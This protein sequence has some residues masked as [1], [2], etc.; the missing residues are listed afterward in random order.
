MSGSIAS[1]I[2]PEAEKVVGSSYRIVRPKREASSSPGEHLG[3]YEGAEHGLTSRGGCSCCLAWSSC[4]GQPHFSGAAFLNPMSFYLCRGCLVR[5]NSDP[6]ASSRRFLLFTLAVSMRW[7]PLFLPGQVQLWAGALPW[8]GLHSARPPSR[9]RAAALHSSATQR[10][11]ERAPALCRRQQK[12]GL[13]FISTISQ[14]DWSMS[15]CAPW[16]G[17]AA[18]SRAQRRG[19]QHSSLNRGLWCHWRPR[20]EPQIPSWDCQVRHGTDKSSLSFKQR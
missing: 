15:V 18:V 10:W 14:L 17:S 19:T 1:Y 9:G 16:R 6:C 12:M 2:Y 13:K 3:W 5:G 7:E 11:H 4:L 8:Q 20:R